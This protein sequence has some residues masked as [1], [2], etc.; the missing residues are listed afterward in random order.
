MLDILFFNRKHVIAALPYL[1]SNAAVN[2]MKDLIMKRYINQATINDWII[3]FALFPQPDHETIE[4]LSQLLDFQHQI[5][6]V[7]FVL[8]YSTII[9]T[10]CKNNDNCIDLE[11]VN[12]FL[13]YLQQKISR[14]CEPRLHSPLVTK[15]VKYL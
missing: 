12:T 1:N 9:Y 13:S 5:P 10:Y 11:E 15:E 4:V 2:V 3:T 6:D 8:S 14:G 7:Q